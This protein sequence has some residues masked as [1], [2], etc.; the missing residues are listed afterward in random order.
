MSK[1]TARNDTDKGIV[2]ELATF[3]VGEGKA[4]EVYAT[5][6]SGGLTAEAKVHLAFD[7]LRANPLIHGLSQVD[8][9]AAVGGMFGFKAG[10][11]PWERQSTGSKMEAKPAAKRAR[12]DTINGSQQGGS[13]RRRSIPGHTIIPSDLTMDDDTSEADDKNPNS[14]DFAR[15]FFAQ[16]RQRYMGDKKKRSEA[17]KIG[18]YEDI[19]ENIVECERFDLESQKSEWWGDFGKLKQHLERCAGIIVSVLS[20][21]EKVEDV[22][23]LLDDLPA[24]HPVRQ[25]IEEF[26]SGRR[27]DDRQ[28]YRE[29]LLGDQA[30]D[31]RQCF[32]EDQFVN[33]SE[34]TNEEIVYNEVR[35]SKLKNEAEE[36]QSDTD[37][38]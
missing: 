26:W 16:V 28:M 20:S 4:V 21:D 38:E 22:R 7:R 37:E 30:V 12:P 11:G 23:P 24:S 1:P 2:E 33:E 17:T 29:E 5:T 31:D 34:M 13:G 36:D 35:S 27:V 9:S 14:S 32:V 18:T 3:G 25:V 10:D 6:V 8:L 19:V 15:E